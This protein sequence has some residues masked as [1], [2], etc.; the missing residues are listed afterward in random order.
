MSPSSILFAILLAGAGDIY[1][2]PDASGTLRFQDKPC[3]SKGVLLSSKEKSA[4]TELLK[5]RQ[6]LRKLERPATRKRDEPRTIAQRPLAPAPRWNHQG[7][8]DPNLLAACSAQFFQC[9]GAN[10]QRMD[11]CVA[12]MPRCNSTRGTSCCPSDCIDRYLDLRAAQFTPAQAVRDALL[13]DVAGSC[14]TR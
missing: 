11:Q 2:C 4:Q 14:A 3:A 13:D 10:T 7:P 5:L 1:H 6:A 12:R 9:A 8:A